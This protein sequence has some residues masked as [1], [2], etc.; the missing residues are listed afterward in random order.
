METYYTNQILSSTEVSQ[1]LDPER[2]RNT[3][4]VPRKG[5]TRN[6]FL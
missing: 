4:T 6:L 3:V 2:I 1:D 5:P